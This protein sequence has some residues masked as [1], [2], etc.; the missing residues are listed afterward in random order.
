MNVSALEFE[1]GAIGR[2]CC[3]EEK[4]SALMAVKE[5]VVITAALVAESID[6]FAGLFMF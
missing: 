3:P 6:N 5:Q 1:T 2:L 4:V